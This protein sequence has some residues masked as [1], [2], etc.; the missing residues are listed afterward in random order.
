MDIQKTDNHLLQKK[1]YNCKVKAG[2]K[3]SGLEKKIA[4][5]K[6]GSFQLPLRIRF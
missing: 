6:R 4:G 1:H 5:K 3:R 2:E